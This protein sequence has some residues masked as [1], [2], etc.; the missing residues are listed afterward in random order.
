MNSSQQ[1]VK[2]LDKTVRVIETLSELGEASVSEIA[3]AMD[4]P[5]S[6]TLNHLNSLEEHEF[7]VQEEK[8][9]RLGYRFL[10][11]GGRERRRANI[12]RH[13]RSTIDELARETGELAN[14]RSRNT[15]WGR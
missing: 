9:Y 4:I 8:A 13:G 5:L 7:V 12:Y 3:E 6:T 14:I 10:E 15:A 2:T 11:I 1:R